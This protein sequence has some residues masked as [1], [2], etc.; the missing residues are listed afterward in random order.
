VLEA[1]FV[2]GVK[3][4]V[5]TSS[6]A[7]LGPSKDQPVSEDDSRF[8][9]FENDYEISKHCAEE[10]VREYA[11]RGLHAVIVAPPRVYGPGLQTKGNPIN[12]LVRDA[13]KRKIAFMPAARD[14]VGNYA[15]IDDVVNGHF[16]ALKKGVSGENYILGGENISYQQLFETIGKAGNENL[17]IIP[18]P[19]ALLK[20]WTAVIFGLHYIIG[21]HTHLS[22]KVVGRL[23]QDR[24]L[25][26]EK[27]MLH[28]G[29]RITPFYQGMK[30]TIQHL[31]SSA[32]D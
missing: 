1:A 23:M 27:A 30:T 11:G 28:L 20:A 15:F 24:A 3:K 29:Y 16:Q 13:L 10:L 7:V 2:H 12:K 8:T 21:R 25:T 32:R 19:V 22:P 5:F 4:M 26:C 14:V 31:R 18:V 6:C 9:P 17:K